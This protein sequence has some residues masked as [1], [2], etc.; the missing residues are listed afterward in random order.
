MADSDIS[1]QI[2]D[3]AGNPIAN[4]KV[5]LWR[6]DLAGSGGLVD[7]SIADSNG[8]FTFEEHPDATNSSQSW[9]VA[10]KDPNGNVQLQSAY[11]VTASPFPTQPIGK[12]NWDGTGEN[13]TGFTQFAFAD[14]DRRADT[15]Q[16]IGLEGT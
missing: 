13:E 15:V 12:I 1:G 11:G 8:N 16:S 7:I 10:A 2:T 3:E 14:N 6:E 5:L 9:H 4:A